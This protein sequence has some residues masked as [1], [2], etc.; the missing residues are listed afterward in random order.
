MVFLTTLDL[1][2][3]VP[4]RTNDSTQNIRIPTVGNLATVQVALQD[5]DIIVTA[6]TFMPQQ[7]SIEDIPVTDDDLLLLD[8]EDEDTE[9]YDWQN[10][11]PTE[12]FD[13]LDID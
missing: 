7:D 13:N 2:V 8:D 11:P 5:D 9:K 3:D 6:A 4:V 12:D 1:E 10:E